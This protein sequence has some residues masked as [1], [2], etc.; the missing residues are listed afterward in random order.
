MSANT[1]AGL[2]ILVGLAFLVG[3][4]VGNDIQDW[5]KTLFAIVVA[6]VWP[7]SLIT[8]IVCVIV[9]HSNYLHHLDKGQ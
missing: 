7:F 9:Q 4:A 6:S 3:W 5:P 2:Y 1:I 8:M